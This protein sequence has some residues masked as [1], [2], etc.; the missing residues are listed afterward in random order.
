MVHIPFFTLFKYRKKDSTLFSKT[1]SS[2]SIFKILLFYIHH[3]FVT[4]S[5]GKYIIDTNWIRI[6]EPWNFDIIL[7]TILFTYKHTHTRTHL[8]YIYN[9]C[10]IA[11]TLVWFTV[12]AFFLL[13]SLLQRRQNENFCIIDIHLILLWTCD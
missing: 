9:A 12:I 13:F 7:F 5:N 8:Y 11:L 1:K 6:Q 4:N 2:N 3:P 10:G